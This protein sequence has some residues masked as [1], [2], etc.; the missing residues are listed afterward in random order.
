VEIGDRTRA[1]LSAV[2]NGRKFLLSLGAL[3][4]RR[5]GRA[6]VVDGEDEDVDF[7]DCCEFID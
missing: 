1:E 2:H 7:F 3:L 6:A 4:A 5:I